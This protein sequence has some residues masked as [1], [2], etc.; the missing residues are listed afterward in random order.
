MKLTTIIEKEDYETC[1][2]SF[3][4]RVKPSKEVTSSGAAVKLHEIT[5]KITTHNIGSEN[6]KKFNQNFVADVFLFV[7]YK[8]VSPTKGLGTF[9]KYLED[10]YDLRIKA[11]GFGCLGIGLECSSVEGLEYLWTDYKSGQLDGIASRCLVT[12]GVTNKAPPREVKLR[13][14]IRDEE[15]V[16]CKES[17]FE[18]SKP[19]TTG[20]SRENTSS[21]HTDHSKSQAEGNGLKEAEQGAEASFTITTRDSEGKQ[22]YSEQ[23]RVTVTIRSPTGEEVA[24]TTDVENGYYKV[25]YKPKKLGRHNVT[26]EINGW[27]L[28]SSPWRVNVKPHQYKVV[29]P[30]GSFGRIEGEFIAPISIA[31][32][33][34]TG[35][36]AVADFVKYRV[37]VFDENLKYPRTIGGETGSQTGA[38]VK[39]GRPVSIAFLRNGDMI[40]IHGAF[41][42]NEMSLITN[43][44]QFIQQFSEH[45]INPRTVSVKADGNGHVVVLD[46]GDRKIKVLSSDGAHL[47]Q[48]FRI[49]DFDID[50]TCVCYHHDKVFL[51]YPLTHC[52]KVFNEKGEYEY[53]IGSEGSGEG[54]LMYPRGLAVDTFDNLIVC[55]SSNS[56]LQMFT[57]DGEFLRSFGKEIYAPLAITV[58][59]NGDLLVTDNRQHCVVHL[60]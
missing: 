12:D 40:V 38:A 17:F 47:L 19:L 24:K 49:P 51:S 26:I 48:F 9:L 15:Y 10:D 25:H 32:N 2:K 55:D 21:R 60:R 31:K 22:F 44:G 11:L 50:V 29:R 39:I 3:T 42:L 59:K 5:V 35:E 33:E 1:R 27:P 34:K 13:T 28:T 41:D 14:F 52:V 37:Q 46:E 57:Q 8:T 20:A 54:Q 56:R 45:L 58:C 43:E 53:S 4:E 23:E 30:Y 18:R 7:N 6:R 16:A 36:I